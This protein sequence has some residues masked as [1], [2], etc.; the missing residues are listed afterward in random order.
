MK[1]TERILYLGTHNAD[2]ITRL[3]SE[4]P[5]VILTKGDEPEPIEK[6]K[7]IEQR[8]E[9]QKLNLPTKTERH[10]DKMERIRKRRRR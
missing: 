7:R 2:R 8:L 9:R 10:R 5:D 6:L 3:L 4:M 1:D